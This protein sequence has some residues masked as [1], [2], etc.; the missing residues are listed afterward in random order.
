MLQFHTSFVGKNIATR[1]LKR[2]IKILVYYVAL[3]LHAK[4]V[5]SRTYQTLV[6]QQVEYATK[7][8]NPCNIATVDRLEHIQRAAANFIHHDYRRTTFINDFMNIL[9][10]DHLHTRLLVSQLI[11]F[12]E[13]HFCLVNI[14]IP[15]LIS[16]ATFIGKHD[17]QLFQY[18]SSHYGQLQILFLSTFSKSL[19]SITID[20]CFYSLTCRIPGYCPISRYWDEVTNWFQDAVF[21]QH[22]F[23][24]T[25]I[26][27]SCCVLAIFSHQCL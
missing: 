20:C 23:L 18:S 27:L 19:E 2:Q 8:W 12:Y 17:H 3:Y 1:S 15:Q 11:M 25:I 10:W 14:H 24:S 6:W 5:K 9:G 26:V 4:G 21:N 7:D 13:I 16:P 22:C